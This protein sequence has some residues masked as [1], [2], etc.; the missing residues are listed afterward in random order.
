MHARLRDQPYQLVGRVRAQVW[1]YEGSR[2]LAHYL[3]RRYCIP[4]LAR[5]LRVPE[6]AVPATV[7]KHVFESLT[8]LLTRLS[9][10]LPLPWGSCHG[11]SCLGK[12]R[13]RLCT[14]MMAVCTLPPVSLQAMSTA[15]DTA[16]SLMHPRAQKAGGP[17]APVCGL[18]RY[19]PMLPV[20][21]LHNA[22]V[23]HRDV[24]PLNL[25]LAESERRF[26]LID[27]GAAAD[28]RN[29]TNWAPDESILD[30]SYCPPEQC[31]PRLRCRCSPTT[32]PCACIP[33][34]VGMLMMYSTQCGVDDGAG[35]GRRFAQSC[36]RCGA[37]S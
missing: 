25:V 34:R 6:A 4:A 37:G 19:L 21:A 32:H 1:R 18:T 26:K 8:V 28:L 36:L 14:P 5:D 33:T 20:Q 17:G 2:T 11:L 29:G 35:V 23:V 7:M 15:G 31:A 30:P 13:C 24:K 16:R 10:P 27:L 9:P 12:F 22:G 3:K